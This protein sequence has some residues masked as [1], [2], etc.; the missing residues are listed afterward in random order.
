MDGFARRVAALEP[1]EGFERSQLAGGPEGVRE[2]QYRVAGIPV[3]PAHQADME[4]LVAD[5]G[6]DVPWAT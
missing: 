2:R 1:I 5:A 6:L 3:G 4:G